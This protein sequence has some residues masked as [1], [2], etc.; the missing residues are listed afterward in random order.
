MEGLNQKRKEGVMEK[1]KL[2]FVPG[3]YKIFDEILVNATDNA[4]RSADMSYIKVCIRGNTVSVEND[5]AG[6]PIVKAAAEDMLVPTMIFGHLL[7]GDNFDDN[8]KRCA[9][10]RNGY[11]FFSFFFWFPNRFSSY[12][13][14]ILRRPRPLAT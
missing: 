9:G 3:L 14:A 7:A 13:L 8:N 2:Q 1:R 10:G 6:I 11:G 5:G 4:Q 12:F